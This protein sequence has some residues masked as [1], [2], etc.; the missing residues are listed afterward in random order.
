MPQQRLLQV[1]DSH[2]PGR[3]QLYPVPMCAKANL[4]VD[5][6]NLLIEAQLA[7][8]IRRIRRQEQDFD[9]LFHDRDM[10]PRQKNS[11]VSA[12]PNTCDEIGEQI[13]SKQ[14]EKFPEGC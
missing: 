7:S 2:R 1:T 13:T 3:N 8:R 10:G 11:P 4:F 14:E 12:R 5:F 9:S 6:T